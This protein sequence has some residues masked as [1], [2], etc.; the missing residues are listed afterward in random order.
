MRFRQWNQ[1]EGQKLYDAMGLPYT[2]PNVASPAFALKELLEDEN[3]KIIAAGAIK[4]IGESFLWIDPAQTPIRRAKAVRALVARAKVEG[5][6]AG[7]EELS[8]WIPPAVEA[9]FGLALHKL[10]WSPSLW[11]NWSIRT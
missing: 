10:G 4:I 1:E 3:G 2:M 9:E 11:R 7:F 6:R 5:A 8:A